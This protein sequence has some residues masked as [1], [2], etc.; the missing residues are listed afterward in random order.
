MDRF[1]FPALVVFEEL[2]HFLF[3]GN[4][5]QEVLILGSVHARLRTHLGHDIG[6][7]EAITTSGQ[8][9]AIAFRIVLV[10]RIGRSIVRIL[11]TV[12]A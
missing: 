6:I 10:L 9:L 1:V 2:T 3:L 7:G 5:R 8:E 11:V 4:V 12:E